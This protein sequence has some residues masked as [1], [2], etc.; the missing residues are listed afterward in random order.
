M[1][2]LM[3]P[4][5]ITK[6][7]RR[8]SNL[9]K[10]LLVISIL[11][12]LFRLP[13]FA[14]LSL[15]GGLNIR[16]LAK[17][18]VIL[19]ILV[20]LFYLLRAGRVKS[21]DKYPVLLFILFTIVVGIN[22]SLI[23]NIFYSELPLTK[24]LRVF[25]IFHFFLIFPFFLVNLRLEKDDYRY[26]IDKIASVVLNIGGLLI[27]FE[28]LGYYLG[29]F[30]PEDTRNFLSGGIYFLRTN[31]Y[32]PIGILADAAASGT[33]LAACTA[34]YFV[35]KISHFKI[36][37]K[38]I[39]RLKYRWSTIIIGI[40]SV[41]VSGSLTAILIL[42]ITI[43]LS[44]LIYSKSPLKAFYVSIAA[45]LF[46]V[47]FRFLP[48]FDIYNYFLNYL[49]NT[50]KYIPIFFP[51]SSWDNFPLWGYHTSPN[52]NT[53]EFHLFDYAVKYGF[54]IFLPCFILMFSPLLKMT[55]L[56]PTSNQDKAPMIL[57]LVFLLAI[58]HYSGF[59]RWGNNYLYTLAVIMLFKK[60]TLSPTHI[61][62][63]KEANHR[64]YIE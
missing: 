61:I 28:G 37:S 12:V 6:D 22:Y 8:K 19:P 59:E 33:L 51:S 55:R 47:C 64:K 30:T 20:P 56:F 15:V 35:Q 42:I 17:L 3:K 18:I 32:R 11:L 5:K 31:E 45:I 46:F 24:N 7:R 34:Y 50:D 41:F 13:I 58:V 21:F 48:T 26:I 43:L 44:M 57:C 1:T 54:L 4:L 40:I 38:H 62:A 23:L 39:Q 14:V 49:H 53:G 63:E 29:W 36:S 2:M 9:L 16:E 10:K 27:I 60:D 25:S 52:W